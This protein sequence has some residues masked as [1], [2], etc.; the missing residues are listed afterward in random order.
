MLK[1]LRPKP[2]FTKA[3]ITCGA[4]VGMIGSDGIILSK[5]RLQENESVSQIGERDIRDFI[6]PNM[7][8]E[9]IK[10]L[11]SGLGDIAMLG[12]FTKRLALSKVSDKQLGQQIRKAMQ[13]KNF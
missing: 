6:D 8:M 1:I 12:H 4:F 11:A 13:T 7:T 10:S 5:H 3:D 2:Y 9:K